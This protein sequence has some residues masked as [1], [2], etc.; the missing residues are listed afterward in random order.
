MSV[1]LNVFIRTECVIGAHRR[2]KS[3][4]DPQEQELETVENH[5]MSDGN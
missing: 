3:V 2:K 5:H 1:L 4:L